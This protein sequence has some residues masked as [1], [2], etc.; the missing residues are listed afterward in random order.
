MKVFV[1]GIGLIGGSL[2]KDIKRE[3]QSATIFGIDANEN[4]LDKALAL[5][6]INK[7]AELSDILKP[8]V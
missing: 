4:N 1:I 8:I 2:A 6:I 5:G 7:K 3:L